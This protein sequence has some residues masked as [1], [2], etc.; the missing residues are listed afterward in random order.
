MQRTRLFSHHQAARFYDML[1]ARLDTQSFY[2][3]APLRELVARLKMQDCRAVLEFGCGTGRLAAELFESFLSPEATYLGLD[4]SGAMVA[5]ATTR[6]ER[7]SARAVVQQCDG[8]PHIEAAHGSFD[9]FICTYVLDLL[10]ENDIRAI[11]GEA[12][13]ILVPDGLVGLASLTSGPTPASRLLSTTWR[14]LHTIS[15][16]LVGGCRPIVIERFLPRS[17][18]A[19]EYVHV[20][21]RFGVPTEIVVA[22]PVRLPRSSSASQ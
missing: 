5:L 17:E 21:T 4:V 19:I 11:I 14:T 18:W 6:L 8:E 10:S 20:V 15:P 7:W 16:W 13:R 12:R 3:D 2:E 9:R 1:G 22:K